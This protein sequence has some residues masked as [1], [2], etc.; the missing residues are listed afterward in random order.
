MELLTVT[1]VTTLLVTIF[2]LLFQYF[3]GLRVA[4]AGLKSEWKRLIMLGIYLVV[5]AIVAWGGCLPAIKSA[6]PALL[7]L[8]EPAPIMTYV[9]GVL[10]AIGAGQGIFT[11]LP[12]LR[13]VAEAKALR[14]G[15][16]LG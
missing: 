10:V 4:W 15:T 7:C 11:A 12:E 6:F 16:V 5:G 2:T 8:A 9:L 14:D 13:D 3:P 1:G